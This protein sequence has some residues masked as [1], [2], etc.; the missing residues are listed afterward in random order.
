M[1]TAGLQHAPY[2]A[3][4]QRRICHVV[5]DTDHCGSVEQPACEGQAVDVGGDRDVALRP[6]QACLSLL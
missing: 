3:Q 1:N 6:P 2:L 4:R 5:Q